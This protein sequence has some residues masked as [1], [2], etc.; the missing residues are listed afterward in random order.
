MADA[1]STAQIP[2]TARQAGLVGC[3]ICGKVHPGDETLCSRC[4]ARLISRDPFSMQ[5]VWAWMAAGILAYIPAN[6]FPMLVTTTLGRTTEN[7][8]IG[9][10]IELAEIGSWDVAI[11]VFFASVMIPIG[12]FVAIAYLA[13]GLRA[14]SRLPLHLRHR[15]YEVVDFVGRW[16]MIDV[17]VVAI[18]S[19]LV[20]LGAAISIKP[21]VAAFSFAVSVACTMLSA[22]SFDSRLI[23]DLDERG[24]E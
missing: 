11:I 8:L 21:G 19:S 6:L 12:K 23:W 2:L 3:R 17:F 13:L 1:G 20:H 24:N 18:L 7:T 22:M 10:I 14:Q 16:S 9:G 15:M 4:G 5:R